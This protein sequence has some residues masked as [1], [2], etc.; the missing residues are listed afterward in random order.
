M[1]MAMTAI[2]EIVEFGIVGS[3]DGT[4]RISQIERMF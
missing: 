4:R 3:I 1:H 2:P